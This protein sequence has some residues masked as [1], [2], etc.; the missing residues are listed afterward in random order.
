MTFSG[1]LK[2]KV[3]FQVHTE[4]NPDSP[5][6]YGN[7]FSDWVTSFERRAAFKHLRGGETIIAARLEGRHTQ[8]IRVRASTETRSVTP[9]WRIVDARDQT[10]YNIRDVTP[11]EGDNAWLDFLV[12]KGVAT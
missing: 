6:D 2:H 7:V 12:E 9:E 10:V 3:A 4:S 1:E 8:I 11:T 5:R